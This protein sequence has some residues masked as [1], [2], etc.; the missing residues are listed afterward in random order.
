M[1]DTLYIVI[2]CY[3]EEE[4]IEKTTH[5]VLSKLHTLITKEIISSES[6]ILFV[7]DGSKDNTWN[8]ILELS[9]SNSQISAIK[10]SKNFGHQNALLAGLNGAVNN[11][12]MI[13]SMDADLQDD[14]NA[15]DEMI[16]KYYEGN[17]IV[18]GVR[19][20]RKKD[21]FFKRSTA[22]LFY[23]LMSLLGANIIDNHADFR[24]MS[25]T[26]V[27]HLQNFKEVNLFLRGII[28]LI[29]FKSCNVY[30]ER[31]ERIAGETKYP[32]KKMIS[33]ALEGITS[34]S[35]KPL[36]VITA[37]GFLMFLISIFAM[38]YILYTKFFLYTEIGWSSLICSIWLLGGIQ[39]LC[40]GI[41]GEYIG[42]IYSE[43]KGRPKFIIEEKINIEE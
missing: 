21:S 35:V 39:L 38:I 16:T 24:L 27:T 28:P 7:N 32:L 2:P 10:L 42:K 43:V 40:L 18:Y 25:K 22:N 36:R 17:E 1:K 8:K 14:I 3:N 19:D 6:K 13:I 12:D 9:K 26:A 5:E 23:K 33:F 20:N 15:I 29:G 34:F 30:Y 37:I 4:I 31:K 41:V 11:A